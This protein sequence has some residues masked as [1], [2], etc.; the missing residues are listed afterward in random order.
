M[1]RRNRLTVGILVV[2]FSL[3]IC[4][5]TAVSSIPVLETVAANGNLTPT[6]WVYLPHL[7]GRGQ[8][9]MPTPDGIVV[10]HN[11]VDADKIPQQWLNQVR[12]LDVFFA[13]KSIGDDILEQVNWWH[14]LTI[15]NGTNPSWFDS[16]DGILETMNF[17]GYAD[18]LDK[19][20]DFDLLV[21]GG[22]HQADIAMMKL[23]T[24]D[25]QKWS[26]VDAEVIW[27]EYRGMMEDLQ[28]DYPDTVFV[29]WTFPLANS[30]PYWDLEQKQIF[31]NAARAHCA[32]T[33]A[34][35]FDLADIVSDGGLCSHSG[36]EAACSEYM[37]TGGHFNTDGS[38][39]LAG[40]L[41]WLLS[42]TAGW[43]GE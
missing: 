41:W 1:K 33:G 29:F 24:S 39:R 21:R 43:D 15:A 18:P 11:A 26:G 23:C 16:H 7:S 13:H 20:A 34:P 17:G 38:R 2:V 4:L 28:A 9:P 22:L 5:L 12:N 35:L 6:A 10:D 36:Y 14:T 3:T 37:G 31:N 25:S 30:H 42:R 40:A 27:D 32:A 19:I 8:S